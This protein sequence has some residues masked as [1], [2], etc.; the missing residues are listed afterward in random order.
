M[1]AAYE[2]QTFQNSIDLSVKDGIGKG[3]IANNMTVTE[4]GF[5]YIKLDEEILNEYGADAGTAGNM[6]NNFNYIEGVYAWALFSF[7]KTAGNIRGSIRSRGPV[8]NTVAANFG[9]GGHIYAS[10]VRLSNFDDV[11][12]LVD[13]LD[14]A[15]E[16][17][18][19][20]LEK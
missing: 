20:D 4:H 1:T 2:T 17:Y 18:M 6:V 5:A 13:A 16:K 15:C 7:D 11:D 14:E 9:G 10:G 3:Y 19:K 8:V 12:K